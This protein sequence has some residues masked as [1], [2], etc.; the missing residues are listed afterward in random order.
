[1]ITAHLREED[2]TSASSLPFLESRVIWLA[3]GS[4]DRYAHVSGL[5]EVAASAICKIL[6]G[7]CFCFQIFCANIRR[8]HACLLWRLIQLHLQ[9]NRSEAFS[10]S[11]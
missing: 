1:M 8:Q 11:I 10:M 6:P 2:R 3:E 5:E 7:V 4:V 9:K